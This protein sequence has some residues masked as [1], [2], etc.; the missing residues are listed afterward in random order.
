MGIPPGIY[1]IKEILG[2]IYTMGGHQGTLRNEI[3]GKKTHFISFKW[4]FWNANVRCKI[5]F[6]YFTRFCGLQN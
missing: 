4:N 3:A 5:R 1:S 2:A 6:Q